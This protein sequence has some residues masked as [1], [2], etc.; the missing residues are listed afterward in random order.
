[1]NSEQLDKVEQYMAVTGEADE[2]IAKA[3]LQVRH[4]EG[5]GGRIESESTTA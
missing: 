5:G 2:E 1:M 4:H 3:T